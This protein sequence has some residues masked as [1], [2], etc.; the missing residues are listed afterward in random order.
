MYVLT[1]QLFLLPFQFLPVSSREHPM[2][3]I[4][5]NRMRQL[6]GNSFDLDDQA[7]QAASNSSEITR[8][9]LSGVP[10]GSA[11]GESNKP[12]PHWDF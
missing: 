4:T 8:K 11:F 1:M 7:D 9:L 6:P 12:R 5:F 3:L 2:D 10:L